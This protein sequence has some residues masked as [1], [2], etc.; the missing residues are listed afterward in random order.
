MRR[1]SEEF[2]STGD[3]VAGLQNVANDSDGISARGENFGSTLQSDAA[4]GDDGF[5]RELARLTNQGRT[6]DRVGIFFGGCRKDG[7][8]GDVIHGSIVGR[9]N[10]LKIV[11]RYADPASGAA[12]AAGVFRLQIL[13]ADMYA[14]G[15]DHGSDVR[16]VIDDKTSAASGQ[17]FGKVGAGFKIF[18]RGKIFGAVL[19]ELDAGIHKFVGAFYDRRFHQL[20][21]QHGI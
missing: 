8:D 18:S 2:T 10:L 16:P 12:N 15:A 20:L 21:I 14:S 9:A 4:N 6:N 11:C 17:G 7:T 13:P 5:A 3:W 1:G 19:N